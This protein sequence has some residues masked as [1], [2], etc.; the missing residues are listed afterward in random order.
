[1][2]RLG[3]WLRTSTTYNPSQTELRAINLHLVVLEKPTTITVRRN[4]VNQTPQVVRIEYL[5]QA[6]TQRGSH[7]NETSRQGIVIIAAKNHPDQISVPNPNIIRGDLF[8]VAS[9]MQNFEV[10]QVDFTNDWLF[11][12][13]AIASEAT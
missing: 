6:F 8:Y 10:I 5:E 7:I 12:A 13:T 11:Q 9:Y 2:T 1:M 4:G 3:N